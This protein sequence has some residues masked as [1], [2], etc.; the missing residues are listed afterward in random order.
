MNDHHSA[1]IRQVR[2]IAKLMA[3]P[4]DP[5]NGNRVT[6]AREAILSAADS[7][8]INQVVDALVNNRSLYW[9]R[10]PSGRR[11]VMTQEIR[12]LADNL[13]AKIDRYG[14]RPQKRKAA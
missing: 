7:G 1:V 12:T 10:T 13:L 11:G 5:K 14:L 3:Q 6:M 4:A 2:Y 9:S 8:D